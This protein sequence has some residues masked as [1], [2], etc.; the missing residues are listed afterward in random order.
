MTIKFAIRDD[1]L[2]YFY[3]PDFI[4]KNLSYIMDICPVSMAAI[5]LVKGN[6]KRNTEILEAAGPYGVTNQMIE[7]IKKDNNA[8]NISSNTELIKYVKEKIQEGRISIAIHG[9]HHRNEDSIL[10]HMSNNFGI[11]AEFE[12]DRDLT[13][14]LQHSIKI[15]ENSFDQKIRVFTPPQNSYSLDGA[16]AVFNNKLGMCG[17]LPGV[18][19]WKKFIYL[20]GV[21]NY[22]NYLNHRMK[23]KKIGFYYPYPRLIRSGRGVISDHCALQPSTDAAVVMEKFK[24]VSDE[25]GNF[26]LST[27]SYGF[28]HKMIKSNETMK[29]CLLRIL[30][31]VS[32]NNDVK[33]VK[34]DEI[35]AE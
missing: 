8:F 4:E 20:F 1:D 16:L 22:L 17:Y 3:T 12:T 27:H 9:I 31:E 14:P 5:P 24:R 18:R 26:V 2:N 19:N 35:F 13:I 11:G 10:P 29:C 15:L 32:K 28:N 6:W 33:F 34:L 30:D 21:E 23:C 7:A 25:G